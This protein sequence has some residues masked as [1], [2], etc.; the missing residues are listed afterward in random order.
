MASFQWPLR[1]LPRVHSAGRYPMGPRQEPHRYLNPATA[2]LHQYEYAGE[3]RIGRARFALRPG[4]VTIT[5][6]GVE[7]FYKLRGPGHHLCIHFHPS[8]EKGGGVEVP[9][10][11]RLGSEAGFVTQQIWA[12][13]EMHRTLKP[14]G[15]A[16]IIDLRRDASLDEIRQEVQGFGLNRFDRLFTYWSFRTLL[17][18]R[19]YSTQ[20]MRNFVAQTPFQTCQIEASG[21]GFRVWLKK[22]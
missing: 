20:E 10:W 19:A 16:L 18:K 2:A 14:G 3:I 22:N 13:A 11:I 7:S 5:P 21:I 9:L 12:I 15:A 1:A 17:L 8:A 6:A 4:D